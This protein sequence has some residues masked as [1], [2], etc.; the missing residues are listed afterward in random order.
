VLCCDLTLPT[1]E[2]NLACDEALLEI[3]EAGFPSPI[4][5]FWSPATTFV[6]AGYANAVAR[7]VNVDACRLLKIPVLRRCT[8]GGTVLQGPGCLNYSVILRIDSNPVL[9][10]IHGTNSYVMERNRTAIQKLLGVPVQ[11]EGH[12][13]LAIEGLKFSGNAQRRRRNALIFHGCFLLN[14]DLGLMEKVLLMPSKRPEYRKDRAH[15]EFVKN[16]AVSARDLKICLKNEWEVVG[17]FTH[18][19]LAEIEQLVR[20]KYSRAEWN[21]KF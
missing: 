6:V 15:T 20:Q 1:P 3:S 19:P 10:G 5:R 7:E 4:L 11:L 12:T 17:T 2:E 14:C 8:G 16:I 18:I 21:Q 13:D 9:E